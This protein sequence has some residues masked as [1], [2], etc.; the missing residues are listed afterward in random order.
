MALIRGTYYYKG[1]RAYRYEVNVYDAQDY[2]PAD[3]T[4]HVTNP[5]GK[6][7]IASWNFRARGIEACIKDCIEEK[8]KK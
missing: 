8:I 3:F 5:E 1:K 6:T 7:A 4:I 2:N